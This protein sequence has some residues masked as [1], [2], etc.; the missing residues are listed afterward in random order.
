MNRPTGNAIGPDIIE[1]AYWDRREELGAS[2]DA[3][4]LGVFT[5]A[6][7]LDTPTKPADD[8]LVRRVDGGRVLCIETNVGNPG[9][10]L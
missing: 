10:V 9:V 7:R 2:V 1:I 5:H 3:V 6:K 4:V 8:L